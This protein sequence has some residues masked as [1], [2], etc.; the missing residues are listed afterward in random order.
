V[1][2]FLIKLAGALPGSEILFD[3]CS[4]GGLKMANRK[5]IK[6]AGMDDSANLRWGIRRARD[7]ERWDSRIAVVAEY[8]MFQNMKHALSMREKWGTFVSDA[9][10]MMSMVHLRLGGRLR[11]SHSQ[12]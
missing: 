8:P 10:N 1:K 7:M 4:P 2:A 11:R 5:V 9:L 3:A 6:A 12:E